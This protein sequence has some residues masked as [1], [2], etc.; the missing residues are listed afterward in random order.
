VR[1]EVIKVTRDIIRYS[2][3]VV[4]YIHLGKVDEA[5]N[6]LW[7]CR[8]LVRGLQEV[9]KDHPDIKYSG[10]V[11]NALSEF[12]E[13]SILYSI[14]TSSNIPSHEDLGI[15][16]VPYI[17]GLADVIGELKRLA[18]NAVAKE[19]LDK[20]FHYLELMDTICDALKA[21]DYPE[22]LIPGVKRKVDVGRKVT[23]DLRSLL[24]DIENRLKL[25][26]ALESHRG[27]VE[28]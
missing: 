21:L 4:T 6:E 10:L 7:K 1:E 2:G 17:Q 26:K 15:H 14:V 20:A 5:A 24:I 28:K 18:L 11:Y 23:E 13:A 8:E 27:L 9:I 25:R 22:A 3:Y 19:E 12:A 16:Y